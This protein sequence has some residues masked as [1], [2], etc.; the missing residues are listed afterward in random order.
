MKEFFGKE[1]HIQM[2]SY[3]L[4]WL[5]MQEIERLKAKIQ[6]LQNERDKE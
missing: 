4:I 3:S 1:V 2:T 6:S 5:L